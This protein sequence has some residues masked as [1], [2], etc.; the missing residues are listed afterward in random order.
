MASSGVQPKD[1]LWDSLI[2]I[3]GRAVLSRFSGL[4][5][6]TS[7][8]A[9]DVPATSSNPVVAIKSSSAGRAVT[10]LELSPL[11]DLEISYPPCIYTGV[12]YVR[13]TERT[14]LFCRS[15]YFKAVMSLTT[16]L[17]AGNTST[18]SF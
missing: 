18:L 4:E 15:S 17:S 12:S 14:L 9:K 3:E 5:A 7:L 16:R 2:R 11:R 6:S 8:F 10:G 13:L 1:A